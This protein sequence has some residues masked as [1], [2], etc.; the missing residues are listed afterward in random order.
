MPSGGT[1]RVQLT[2]V[3]AAAAPGSPA[4]PVRAARIDIEDQGVG[5]SPEA[6]ARI[7]EPF[8]TTKPEG[9][10]TGLG[11]SVAKGIVEEHGGWL[12][13]KSE[14]GHGSTFSIYLPLHPP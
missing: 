2:R 5:I 9:R 12:T 14:V 6:L 13:A 4:P 1:I 11:L 3:E 8:Y 7:F 10:G